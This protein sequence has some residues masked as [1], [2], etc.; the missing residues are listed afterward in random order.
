MS[1]VKC[2]V[3]FE[4]GPELYLYDW[5]DAKPDEEEILRRCREMFV[6]D[7]TD[8]TDPF[9]PSYVIAEFVEESEP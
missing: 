5:D 9:H 8:S 1:K 3:S 4:Y 7:I 6:E 2:T